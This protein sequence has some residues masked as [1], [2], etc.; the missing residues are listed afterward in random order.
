MPPEHACA[1]RIR[2]CIR[3][4]T[5]ARAPSILIPL[6]PSQRKRAHGDDKSSPIGRIKC[7]RFVS[8]EVLAWLGFNIATQ[9]IAGAL[10]MLVGAVQ[11]SVWALAKHRPAECNATFSDDPYCPRLAAHY[12]LSVDDTHGAACSLRQ[13]GNSCL[14]YLLGGTRRNLMARTGAS[15]TQRGARPSCHSC[16]EKFLSVSESLCLL[17]GTGET[18]HKPSMHF[19]SRLE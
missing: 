2:A 13:G 4:Q 14:V 1:P 5:R 8:F 19:H 9:T 6:A 10:F 15:C 17:T 7:W 11:M 12:S 18:I 3:A 16:C